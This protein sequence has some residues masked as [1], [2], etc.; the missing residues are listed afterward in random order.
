[1]LTASKW[2][3]LVFYEL[4]TNTAFV[5]A[6]SDMVKKMVMTSENQCTG[7]DFQQCYK[8]DLLLVPKARR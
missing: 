2:K 5:C 3:L 7:D 8:V 1:M 4:V 6:E